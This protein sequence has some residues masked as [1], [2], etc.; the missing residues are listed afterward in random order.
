MELKY[1]LIQNVG[2]DVGL[3]AAFESFSK[4]F[5]DRSHTMEKLMKLTKA[6]GNLFP[7]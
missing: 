4:R 2:K 1:Y 5:R 6:V 7:C 3:S